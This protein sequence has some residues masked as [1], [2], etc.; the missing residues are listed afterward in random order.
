MLPLDECKGLLRAAQAHEGG[1]LVPYLALCLFGGLRPFEAA[2]VP[3]D[4]VNLGDGEIRIK[5]TQTKTGKGRI[6]EI[7]PTLKAWLQVYKGIDEIYR[8]SFAAGLREVRSKIGYGTPT[9]E[10]PDL[11]PWVPDTLRHTAISHYFRLTG[12]YGRSAEQFGNSEAIIKR[13]YQSRVSSE[14][15]KQFYGIL[16]KAKAKAAAA[17]VAAVPA[18]AAVAAAVAAAP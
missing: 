10:M 16:P 3:W 15:T 1:R 11:K 14:E 9:E 5:S 2:R 4:Q 7:Q 18:A 13:H 6:V 8:P 17:P 12:S